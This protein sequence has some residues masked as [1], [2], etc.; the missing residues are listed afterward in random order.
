MLKVGNFIVLSCISI[1]QF[2]KVGVII[3][4]KNGSAGTYNKL[5]MTE[6]MCGLLLIVFNEKRTRGILVKGRWSFSHHGKL[7]R[8]C[9]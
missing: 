5:H 4:G 7:W 6:D 3:K 9:V 2:L 1:T 8:L